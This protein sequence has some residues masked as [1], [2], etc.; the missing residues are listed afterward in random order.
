MKKHEILFSLIKVPLDGIIIFGS[1]FLARN[2]REINDFVPGVQ[3][4][5]QIIHNEFLFPFAVFWAF[6]YLVIFFIHGL[7]ALKITSSKVKETFDIILYSIYWFLF[8]SV[9]VYFWKW[10]FYNVEI[11]RLVILFTTLIGI[12]WV[13]LERILLNK[14]QTYMLD[15]GNIPKRNILLITNKNE[16]D[17]KDIVDDIKEAH[18][19]HIIWYINTKQIESKIKYMWSAK[20]FLDIIEKNT[21]DEI[22]YI[23]SDFESEELYNIW[24]FSRIYGIRYRYITNWFDV[25]KT[26][27]TVSLLNKIPVVEIKNTSLWAWGRVIKRW[28]DIIG[29]IFW[30]ILSIPI[31]II[32][33]ILIKWEDPEGPVIYKNLRVGQ[34]GRKFNLYKFRYL[35]WRYCIK[36]SYWIE[37][38]KDDALEFEQQLIEKKSTRYG[39]LYKIKDD[40]RKTKIG[41]FIEKYSLDELPQLF[42]VF[43]WNMSLV[44]PRPHQPREVEKY[45][46]HQKRVL[47][48]K[49]WITGLAQVNGREKNTFDDEVNLDIFYIENWNFLLDVKIF[50]KTFGIILNR[51]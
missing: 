18:I 36:E 27:T 17:I 32:I 2:L 3:L 40:P 25:T 46:L 48:I 6:L 42:N 14:I 49:P 45:L 38:Q 8:F 28:I 5:V 4:P 24:D 44:G 23:D 19:Y 13:I 26:N 15:I 50:F 41:N 7:Y 22:L 10:I 29:S 35:K 43:L 20:D 21:L 33:W 51:K 12:F 1:F 16:Y 47:T 9:F 11:P 37:N 31:F 39:P 34:N 30:L